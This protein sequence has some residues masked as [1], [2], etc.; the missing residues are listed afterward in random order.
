MKVF[1]TSASLLLLAL[2][3][4]APPSAPPLQDDVVEAPTTE[5]PRD[6]CVTSECHTGVKDYEFLHGPLQVNACDSCHRLADVEA[7]RFESPRAAEEMCSL[8]HEFNL[9]DDP[10]I[11]KPLETGEC[12]P[13]HDPHGG[14]SS[15]LLRG[16]DYAELCSSC[17]EDVIGARQ[18]LHGPASAGACGA[19]HEPH[20]SQHRMLL[21]EVGNE[22]C[23]RCHIATGIELD[24][25]HVVHPPVLDNC[26]ICHNPHATDNDALLV[27]DAVTLCMSCHADIAHTITTSATQHGAITAERSCL[28]C[29]DAHASD[30]P[31]LLRKDTMTLCL[32]CHD[33]PLDRDEGGQI[34][35]MKELLEGSSS[36]HGPTA[37][38]N[39][40]ACHRIHGSEFSRLLQGEYSTEIYLPFE[41]SNY[42]LCFTCHDHQ[43]VLLEET[44]AVTSFR[45][46]SSNLHFIHVNRDR[47]GRACRVCHDSHAANS[48]HHIRDAVPFGPGGWELPINWVPTVDGGQCAGACHAEYEYNRKTPVVYPELQKTG[49]DWR[50]E[51]LEPDEK[52]KNLQGGR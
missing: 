39:C 23:L 10:L 7:H 29:H 1:I 31:R 16:R 43:A 12:L 4:S 52:D 19:C 51:D 42:A 11:H 26:Q 36:L 21:Q 27:D 32:E 38:R 9:P 33:R 28:H 8:C 3:T 49:P 25:K 46:G 48:D 40:V 5:I 6:G 17:H 41:D 35:N 34:I 14:S 45:N 2:Q 20:T 50:G 44:E 47:K 13:C 30:N 24:T 15:N 37:Q 22:L 18:L